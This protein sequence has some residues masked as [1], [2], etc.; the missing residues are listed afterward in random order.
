MSEA[1]AL[2]AKALSAHEND[3]WGKCRDCGW[4]IDE[5]GDDDWG[6]Q[7]NLHQAAV[8]AALP[9]IAIIDSQPEPERHVLAVESDIEDQ[10][11]EP[12]RF[13]RTTDGHWWKGYVN[14]G[15][16]Y[17]TWPELVRRYGALQVAGGES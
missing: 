5:Q 6:L 13:G 17:L 14:G 3:G 7:F 16:V 11:G 2:I 4:S 10:Y 1:Q 8:I 15:K 9:G 12:I